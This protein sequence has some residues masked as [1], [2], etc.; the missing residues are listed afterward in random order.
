MRFV[1][2]GMGLIFLGTQDKSDVFVESLRSLPNLSA[3]WSRPSSKC[4][5][6]PAP[7]TFSRSRSFCTCALSITRR[8]RSRRRTSFARRAR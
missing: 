5:P 1:A 6:M 3:A 8:R 2:L 4:A 7:A